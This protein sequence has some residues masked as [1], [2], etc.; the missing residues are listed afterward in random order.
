MSLLKRTSISYFSLRFYCFNSNKKWS[1]L[2]IGLK[3]PL[4]SGTSWSNTLNGFQLGIFLPKDYL[5]WHWK[6]F[7]PE[8]WNSDGQKLLRLRWNFQCGFL[9][10]LKK[11]Y[12]FAL[13]F[14][15]PTVKK[16]FAILY[17]SF[18]KIYYNALFSTLFQLNILCSSLMS[19]ELKAVEIV[20]IS[21]ILL[22]ILSKMW[23]KPRKKRENALLEKNFQIEFSDFFPT[24]I[25]R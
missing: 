7:F 15:L 18:L 21:L 11:Y 23:Q 20:Q 24:Y 25:F 22:E 9:Y 14:Y 4:F 19:C 13:I 5:S 16:L 2:G 8:P 3:I 6:F 17:F 10:L 12:V 1:L